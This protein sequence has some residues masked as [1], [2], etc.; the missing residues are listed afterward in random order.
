MVAI[1]ALHQLLDAPDD[2]DN[3]SQIGL[4]IHR[5]QVACKDFSLAISKGEVFGLL[6]PNGAGKTTAINMLIGFLTPSHGTV[7]AAAPTSRDCA[8]TL[9]PALRR[10]RLPSPID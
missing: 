9:A 3:Q 4:S 6:G 5:L 7:R 2:T 8:A 10:Q 1:A